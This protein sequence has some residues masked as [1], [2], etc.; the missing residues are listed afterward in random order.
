MKKF[1]FTFL[2]IVT[3][4]ILHAQK[5]QVSMAVENIADGYNS[6]YRVFMPHADEKLVQSNW[7]KFLKSNKAKVRGSKSEMRGEN[8]VIR[9]ISSDSMDVYSR[10]VKS[11]SGITLVAAF[12]RHDVFINYSTDASS[13]AQLEQVLY[14]FAKNQSVQSIDKKVASDNKTLRNMQ[15]EKVSRTRANKRMTSSNESMRKQIEKNEKSIESNIQRIE[16]LTRLI[17]EQE[18]S[19]EVTKSKTKEL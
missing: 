1:V 6:A 14:D 19:I 15:K 8:T 5:V 13:A 17:E 16:E 11:D 10:T 4:L 7:K 9:G 2:F 3:S 12:E 18:N